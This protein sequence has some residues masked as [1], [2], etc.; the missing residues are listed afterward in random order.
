MALRE[1][2]FLAQPRHCLAFM[3][4]ARALPMKGTNE[5][6]EHYCRGVVECFGAQY[7]QSTIQR[8]HSATASS[9]AA[10]AS[11]DG[12]GARTRGTLLVRHNRHGGENLIAAEQ[13][14]GSRGNP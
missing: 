14:E 6:D 8:H 9:G 4:S 5:T 7:E 1:R 12:D 11:M 10:Q 3:V 2:D 13:P